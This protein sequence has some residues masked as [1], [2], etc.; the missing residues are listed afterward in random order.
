MTYWEVLDAATHSL[1]L[2]YS[3]RP[4]STARAFVTRF[5]G[6]ELV[7]FSPPIGMAPAAFREL[8][9][10]GRVTALV[11]PNGFHYLG[12]R[13]ALAAFPEAT[14]YAPEAALRRVEKKQPD[15]GV[16]PLGELQEK[17]ESPV[18]IL[19]VPGFSIGDTWAIVETSAG[20]LWYVSDSCFNLSKLPESLAA[21]LLFKWTKSGP[22][23]SLN[24]VGNLFFLKDRRR[25]KHWFEDRLAEPTPSLLV[26]AHGE[27][28]R[29][30]ALGTSLKTLVAARL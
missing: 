2:E 27:I 1:T 13:P 6:D 8:E 18:R 22:G 29:E 17:T 19:D 30:H 24:G 16:R 28:A 5:S 25:F 21:R 12:L 4:D 3:F 10:H 26:P 9:G 11:A 15:L 23:L 20:P 7:I 14:L